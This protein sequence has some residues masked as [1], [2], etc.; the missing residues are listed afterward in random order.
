[1]VT[2]NL[3][4]SAQNPSGLTYLDWGI[5][6]L[7]AVI[8]LCIGLY[9]SRKK[10]SLDSYFVGDRD[11]NPRL[12]GI[13]LFASLL[14][15]VSYLAYPGEMIAKGPVV[16]YSLLCY[17]AVYLVVGYLFIPFF[18]KQRVTS[19]YELLEVNLGKGIRLLGA[20]L[21]ILL[22]L[23]WMAFLIFLAAK[24]LIVML[25]I[26]ERW[27]PVVV[28]ISGMVAVVYTSLG[29]L[30]AVVITDFLQSML[31]LGGAL[32]VIALIS[33]DFGNLGWF[34]TTWQ[35]HWDSQ[36]L[37]S[38]DPS[39]RV[40]LFGTLMHVSIWMVCT[41][42]GDQLAIQRYMSTRDVATARRSLR[43]GIYFSIGVVITLCCV[44]FALMGYFKAHGQN[45]PAG[46]NI[47][48]NADKL[49][50]YFIA[51]YMPTGFSG[52]VVAAMFA[53]AMSSIDS[54]IN[55][56]TAVVT[57]DLRGHF[58][59]KKRHTNLSSL[60]TKCLAFGIGV[61]VILLSTV[62]QYIPGNIFAVTQ[63]SMNL[64]VT[65]IF[66]LFFFA[67]FVPFARPVGVLCGTLGGIVTAVLI[68]FS[69][70]I[71]GKDPQTE[72]DPISFQWILPCALAVNLVL[73]SLVSLVG[74]R[75]NKR[76]NSDSE[77]LVS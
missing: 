20:L 50:P 32:L 66:A 7:Y 10:D 59:E 15:T 35:S 51:N 48:A 69:G 70:P 46:I 24:A 31:L 3:T 9:Y 61:I 43:T 5:I 2:T 53:A 16:L 68:A 63:K 55:S 11:M 65:P 34:P 62:F 29:G 22:R 36:P 37:F 52:L 8:T 47:T 57:S 45:L 76:Q 44:G 39:I 67:L 23:T 74:G 60:A 41:Y 30:R 40:T 75:L 38:W 42:G 27:V 58:D 6:A 33:W 72:L 28:T 12:V 25:A 54:G 1:M 17:P 64:L 73:G 4:S 49:F 71:F 26:S 13:S 19:A 77:P 21:F 14:S 18:M 56:I